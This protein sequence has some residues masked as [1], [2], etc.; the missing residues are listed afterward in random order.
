MSLQGP[1]VV[2]A[3]QSQAALLQALAGAGAFPVIEA[4][5][6]DAPAAVA[7]IKPSAVVLADAE[8]VDPKAAQALAE[9]I[10]RTEPFLPLFARVADGNA[11]VLPGTLPI[12]AD[13]PTERLVPRI[14]MALRLRAL[15]ATVLGRAK[16]LKTDRNIIADLPAHDTLDDATVL[17]VG[18]GRSHPALSVAVG[19]RMAVMGALSVEAAARCLNARHLDGIV[20]GDGLPAGSVD[21]FLTVLAEDVRFRD[22]P[23]ALLGTVDHPELPNAVYSRDSQHLIENLIPLVQMHAFEAALKRLLKSIES[24]G[25]LEAQTGLFNVDAFGRELTRVIADTAERGVGL[26]LARFAF[27]G[28]VDRRTHL[29]AARLI[30]RLIR[31]V[32]FACR[33]DESSMLVAFI[34]TD[35]RTAHV[36]ARRLASVLKH[37]ALRPNGEKAQLTPAVTLATLRPND[38]MLT[39]L[40]RVAP[41]RVAA[42]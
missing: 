14:A 1:I 34:D 31:D 25:M 28:E 18:R 40:T 23:V 21:A 38:T 35:L 16:A 9:E 13:M 36:V 20:I 24:K 3:E 22:L 5:L 29:D 6:T 37:T 11:S 39:L 33:Q 26:S 10:R 32:D 30:G 4:R 2:V 19:E 42:E 41:R 8:P 12:P 27:E 15:H 17:V 7:S